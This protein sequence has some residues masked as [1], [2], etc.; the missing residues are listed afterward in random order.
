[1]INAVRQLKLPPF[2]GRRS[3]E[4]SAIGALRG[5]SGV[6]DEAAPQRATSAPAKERGSNR[7]KASFALR[8]RA[9]TCQRGRQVVAYSWH[10]EVV[11]PYWPVF[12][13]G[14]IVTLELT[15]GSAALG[16]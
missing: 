12:V 2:P 14:A 5:G 1:M 6:R 3:I 7:K 4:G 11:T 8:R 15:F 16:T 13:N 9:Q 10:F